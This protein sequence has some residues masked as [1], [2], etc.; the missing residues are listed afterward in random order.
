M[1]T[2]LSSLIQKPDGRVSRRLLRS[3]WG[4]TAEAGLTAFTH[5]D[6]EAC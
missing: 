4:G 5:I 2:L 1:T 3:N 6:D